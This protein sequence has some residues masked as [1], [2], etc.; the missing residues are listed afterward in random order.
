MARSPIALVQGPPGSGKTFLLAHVAAAL[1]RRGE[2]LLVAAHTHRAVNNTLRKI[3]EVAPELRVVKA[4]RETGAD[5][6]RRVRVELAPSMRKLPAPDGRNTVVGTTVLGRALRM[7]PAAVR[8]VDRGRGGANPAHVCAVRVLDCRSIPARRRSSSTGADRHGQHADPLSGVS[9]FEYLAQTYEPCVLR[10]TYR[11]NAGI[12]A[13]PSRT[14]YSGQLESAPEAPREDS[15]PFREV[16]STPCSTRNR[17]RFW[18]R[19]TTRVS[20]RA[21][22][23]KLASSPISRSTCWRGSGSP[24]PALA[25]VS[26]YRA[27]LRAIRTLIRQGL[28]AAGAAPA[29]PVIDTDRANPGAGARGRSRVAVRVRSGS[30]GRGASAVLLLA[31]SAQRHPDRG[32]GPSS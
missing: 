27:Q 6:L 24:R 20:A 7:E 13:F 25:I 3:A 4:G 28:A 19:W 1:A 32:R 30:P 23:R 2:R 31:E 26:P 11:M 5:D 16:H 8:P 21:A 10:R 22:S 18:S 17:P 14:F 9:V 29:L 15:P 12:N